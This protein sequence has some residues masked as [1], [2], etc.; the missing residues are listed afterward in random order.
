MMMC[1]GLSIDEHLSLVIPEMSMAEEVFRLVDSDREHLGE[2]LDFIDTS[3]DVSS[4]I[5]Y[6]KLKLDGAAKGTDRLFL[7]ALDHTIVGCIDLHQINTATGKA[8]VG[9]WLHS[10]YIGQSIMTRAVKTLSNYSFDVLGLNKLTIFAD[11]EN[12]GSNKV[13]IKS[14]FKLVGI[15]YQD[16]VRNGEYRDM[17][18]YYLLKS[19]K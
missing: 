3:V 9:Y 17:N 11:I 12:M 6:F 8:E 18:E 7:I 13:A 15:K 4:Q 2:F 19:D 5:N 1:F 14:G 10:R 16:I